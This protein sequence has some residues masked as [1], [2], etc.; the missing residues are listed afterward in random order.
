MELLLRSPIANVDMQL[1]FQDGCSFL[2]FQV[3]FKLTSFY[4]YIGL[5][6]QKKMFRFEVFK[7]M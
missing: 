4:H 6:Y 1:D 5:F 7:A 3:T 2:E